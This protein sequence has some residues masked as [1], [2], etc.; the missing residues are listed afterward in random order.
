MV[1]LG[2]A[3]WCRGVSIVQS[4]QFFVLRH[5]M[6]APFRYTNKTDNFILI[7]AYLRMGWGGGDVLEWDPTHFGMKVLRRE[8]MLSVTDS[9][10]NLSL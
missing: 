3:V 5:L 1:S 9:L 4:F 10:P 2:V 6:I 8:A 7:E